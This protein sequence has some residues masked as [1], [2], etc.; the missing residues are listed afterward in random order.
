MG[1]QNRELDLD[2]SAAAEVIVDKPQV[3]HLMSHSKCRLKL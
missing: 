2:E 3:A 1:N